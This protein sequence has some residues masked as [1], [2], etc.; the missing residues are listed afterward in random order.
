MLDA[1]KHDET[2]NK[3]EVVS[4]DGNIT[5]CLQP[6]IFHT[7]FHA[8]HLQIVRYSLLP[9]SSSFYC[10]S[11]PVSR[12]CRQMRNLLVNIFVNVLDDS[13]QPVFEVD[14]QLNGLGVGADAQQIGYEFVPFDLKQMSVS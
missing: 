2:T 6:N 7:I 1:L 14:L 8:S 13:L 5:F 12:Q 11:R 4:V 9:L 3:L 10:R